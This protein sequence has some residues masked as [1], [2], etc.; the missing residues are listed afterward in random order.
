MKEAEANSTTN[1]SGLLDVPP[2][3]K[4]RAEAKKVRVELDTL[5]TE[6]LGK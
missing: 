4:T 3:P 1:A 5:L 6:Q 2:I